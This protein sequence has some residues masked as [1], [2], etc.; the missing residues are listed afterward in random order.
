MAFFFSE[1]SNLPLRTA[2]VARA[3]LVLCLFFGV[4]AGAPAWSRDDSEIDR[5]KARAEEN[6]Q[7][8]RLQFNFGVKLMAAKRFEEAAE[9]N[10]RATEADPNLAQAWYNLGLALQNLNRWD[11]AANAYKQATEVKPDYQEAFMNLGASYQH[12][13]LAQEAAGAY[14]T[15]AQLN[16]DDVEAQFGLAWMLLY[17]KD[18]AAA[19][20]QYKVLAAFDKARADNLYNQYKK[21]NSEEP[22][23]P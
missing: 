22:P 10:Q 19:T 17:L 14:R 6:P 1:Q 21:E 4:F 9:A 12:Q 13:K 8:A 23:V 20:E 16:P 7:D 15:A 18:D 3:L 2:P 5:L 11:E